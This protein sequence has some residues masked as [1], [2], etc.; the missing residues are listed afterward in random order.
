MPSFYPWIAGGL[1]LCMVMGTSL[2]ANKRDAVFRLSL[3]AI[4][5]L[6]FLLIFFA[7]L[8]TWTPHPAHV[9]TGVQGRYFLVPALLLG[10]VLGG[11]TPSCPNPA[12]TWIRGAVTAAFGVLS[13]IGLAWALQIRYGA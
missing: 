3:L 2:P 7:L 4:A 8:V 12:L 9:I 13:T 5:A 10:Y 11:S 6:S 1:L